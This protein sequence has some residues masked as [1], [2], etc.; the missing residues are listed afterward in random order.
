MGKKRDKGIAVWGL[1]GLVVLLA[2]VYWVTTKQSRTSSLDAKDIAFSLEDTA[3]VRSI[4]LSRVQEG[5][6]VTSVSLVRQAN[7]IWTVNETY[8]AF[9]PQITQILTT[10]HRMQ[11]KETLVGNGLISADKILHLV[12]TR[13]EVSGDNGKPIKTYLL[14]TESKASR[15]SLMK[16]E[17]ASDPYIVERPDLQGYINPFFNIDVDIWREKLL[18]RAEAKDLLEIRIEWPADPERNLILSHEPER[19][20]TL[21]PDGLLPDHDRLTQYLGQFQGAVFAESFAERTYPDRR[22]ALSKEQPD[23]RF[24]LRYTDGRSRELV[25][26]ARSENPNSYFGWIIGVDELYTVQHFVFDPFLR[27]PA[28]L[29]PEVGT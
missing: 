5:K 24:I 28:Q 10:M 17:G 29:L 8:R 22:L 19:P 4:R 18:W 15:G 1:L 26:Y 3:A 7:G 23:I 6:E 27:T 20:W 12:H 13:I 14:G 25:L 21:Q 11:V 9:V 2:G 16:L